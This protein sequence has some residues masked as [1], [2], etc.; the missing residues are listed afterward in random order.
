MTLRLLVKEKMPWLFEVIKFGSVGSLGFCVDAGFLLLLS[1]FG[2]SPILGRVLSVAAAVTLTWIL[3]RRLTFGATAP[4]SWREFTHYVAIS[5]VGFLLNYT[6][7]V[8]AVWLDAP[9][10]LAVAAGTAAGM[11]FNFFRYR[12]LL[13]QGAAARE[14]QLGT[15]PL[16]GRDAEG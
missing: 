13:G 14:A 8:I 11:V 3:N 6:A 12:A 5:L 2:V 16:G 9:L 4:P 10:I 7:F 15:P 1:G